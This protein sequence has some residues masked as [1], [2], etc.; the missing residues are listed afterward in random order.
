MN[1][2]GTK[3]MIEKL[4]RSIYARTRINKRQCSVVKNRDASFSL[5]LPGWVRE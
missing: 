2:G 1:G 4:K 5:L 3:W